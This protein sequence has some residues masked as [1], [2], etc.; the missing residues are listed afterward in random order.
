MPDYDGYVLPRLIDLGMRHYPEDRAGRAELVPR[1]LGEVLE[2]GIGSGLNFPFY[3]PDVTRLHGVDPSEELLT[4]AR[5][6]AAKAPFP[7]ELACTLNR[8]IAHLIRSA[9]FSIDELQTRYLPGP[10]PMTYTYE[11]RA[12]LSD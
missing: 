7:V 3:S 8:P 11:G 4:M 5:R 12:S 2:I 9:G 10:K 1:A 6:N